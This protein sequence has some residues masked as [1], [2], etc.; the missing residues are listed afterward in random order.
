MGAIIIVDDEPCI[1]AVLR[2][3]YEKNRGMRVQCA[4]TGSQATRMLTQQR[5]DL[6]L[7]DVP[8][9]GTSSFEL[10]ALAAGRNTPVLLMT[11][12][13]VLHLTMQQ[14]AFPYVGKPFTLD[15]LRIAV[16]QVMS[17]HERNIGCV[18]T[19]LDR[20]RASSDALTKAMAES[21]RL[22]DV[23]RAQEQLGHW[24]AA[25][26]RTKDALLDDGTWDR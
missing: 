25:V 19:S 9:P 2:D 24:N 16:A 3:F 4:H 22:L 12:G 13:P 21:D 8:L 15:A 6:A 17:D 20:M 10:A 23:I 11:G 14:F 1:C 26:A 18:R 7:I 5:Y